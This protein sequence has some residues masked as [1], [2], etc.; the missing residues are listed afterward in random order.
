M[1][2]FPSGRDVTIVGISPSIDHAGIFRVFPGR[3]KAMQ[4]RVSFP[5]SQRTTSFPGSLI[6]P[7][8]VR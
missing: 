4:S 6:L 2:L 8:A 7:V 3:G 1:H 5:K